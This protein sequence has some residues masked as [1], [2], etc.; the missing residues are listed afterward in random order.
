MEK[1]EQKKI[2]EN[3][4]SILKTSI[5]KNLEYFPE[6][7]D[8]MEIRQL[9]FNHAKLL[10]PIKMTRTRMWKFLDYVALHKM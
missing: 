10:N 2:V 8:D 1:E 7:W 6:S 3:V 5:L 4:C 9:I